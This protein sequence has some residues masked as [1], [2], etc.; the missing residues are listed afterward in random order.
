MIR[1][2]PHH[3][4]RQLVPMLPLFTGEKVVRVQECE[5]LARLGI[6]QAILSRCVCYSRKVLREYESYIVVPQRTQP[7]RVLHIGLW[8]P[9]DDVLS[10]AH[11][12]DRVIVKDDCGELIPLVSHLSVLCISLS[13]CPSTTHAHRSPVR[14]KENAKEPI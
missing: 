1:S 7:S 4:R 10:V 5:F 8:V 13:S 2:V 6:C 11:R 9:I 12:L 3:V 14:T